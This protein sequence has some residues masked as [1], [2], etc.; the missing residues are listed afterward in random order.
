[1]EKFK[2]IKEKTDLYIDFT[3]EELA[4]LKW[5]KGQRLSMESKDDGILIKPYVKVEIDFSDFPRETLMYLIEESLEKDLP[6]NDVIVEAL[7]KG[8]NILDENCESVT[9]A[10]SHKE[11][12]I[13]E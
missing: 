1:M 13:C 9:C 10:C 7:K 6:V 4:E 11:E 8:L 12:L 2:K 5:E 3:D